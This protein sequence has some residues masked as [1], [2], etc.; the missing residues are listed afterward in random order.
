MD[1]AAEPSVERRIRLQAI[2]A[3]YAAFMRTRAFTH[4]VS[5]RE[6]EVENLRAEIVDFEPTDRKSEIES[7]KLRGDLRTTREFLSLFED[8]VASLNDTID[9]LVASEQPTQHQQ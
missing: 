8:T 7:Y 9:M 2:V 3:E 6:A 4:Y 1:D 5:G